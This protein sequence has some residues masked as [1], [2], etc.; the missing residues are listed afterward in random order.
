MLCRMI[1]AFWP[2]MSLTQWAVM[3][4]TAAAAAALLLEIVAFVPG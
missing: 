1:R 3:L 2:R 4:S